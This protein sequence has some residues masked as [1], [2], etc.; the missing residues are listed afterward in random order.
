[1]TAK[2]LSC[3]T[4]EGECTVV[5]VMEGGKWGPGGELASLESPVFPLPRAL[6]LKLQK[7]CPQ[8]TE[9]HAHTFT[10]LIERLER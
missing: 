9:R 7:L 2:V 6:P 3:S 5:G 8:P 4:A 10:F 1:M